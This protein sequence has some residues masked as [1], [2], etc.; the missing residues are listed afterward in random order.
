MTVS[1]GSDHAG[2]ATKE[3]ITDWLKASGICVRDHGT[4]AAD[5][6]D[7]PD[8]IHPVGED[9]DSGE[10]DFGIAIC[11]SGNGAAMVANKH[12]GVRCALC[13]NAEL[14]ELARRHNDANV[15]SIPARFVSTE[16]AVEMVRI[17]LETAFEGGRHQR[18]IDKIPLCG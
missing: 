9:I 17:F 6:V 13:W 14:A 4:H 16:L 8:Y 7:Y 11:G 10:A 3:R 18:R 15:L 5:A 1:I 2:F 12:L